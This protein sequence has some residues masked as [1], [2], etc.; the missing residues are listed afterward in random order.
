[1]TTWGIVMEFLLEVWQINQTCLFKLSWGKGHGLD[2]QMPFPKILQQYYQEWTTAYQGY[3]TKIHSDSHHRPETDDSNRG[4]PGIT[5]SVSTKSINWETRLAFAEDQLVIAFRDWLRAGELFEI[6]KTINAYVNKA[7]KP[8]V[9]LVR[10]QDNGDCATVAADNFFLAKLPWE[11]LRADL[12]DRVPIHILRTTA[13]RPV[14]KQQKRR[15]RLRILAVFGDDDGL[16]F[17]AERQAIDQ[18]LK[19]IAYVQF[20]GYNISTTTTQTNLKT[21]ISQAIKDPQGWDILFFA[22]H[23]D[24]GLGGEVMLAPGYSALISEFEDALKIARD[25]GLQFALFNSCRGCAIA[26]SLISYGLSHVVVMRERVSNQVAQVFFQEF[27]DRLAKLEDV[28]MAAFGATQALATQAKERYQHPSAYLLPSIYAYPGVKPLKPP[29]LNWRVIASMLNPT[30]W[31]AIALT[32]LL[33]LSCQPTVQYPLIDWRQAAQ[34]VYRTLNGP[35]T[36]APPI[37]LVKL[38]DDS[39]QSEKA[40][41]N[42]ID[43]GYIAKLM[44][45]AIDLKIP[46]VGIDY[47]LKD[48]MPNQAAVKT[49]A[50]KGRFIF[51]ASDEWGVANAAAVDPGL[52]IDGDIGVNIFAKSYPVFLARTIGDPTKIKGKSV[53]LH[54]FPYQ[55]FCQYQQQQGNCDISD[56][57]VY[58]NPITAAARWFGQAWLNPWIDYSIPMNKVYQSISSAEFLKESQSQQEIA[59]L[60]P[61]EEFDEYQFPTTHQESRN[62]A[63]MA[64]GEIHAYLLYN[65]LHQGLIMPFPDLWMVGIVG[66]ISKVLVFWL[67]QRPKERSVNRRGWLLLL[68]GIPIIACAISL[69][70]YIGLGIAIPVLF[71]VVTYFSYVIPHWL[72]QRKVKRRQNQLLNQAMIK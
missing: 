26:E 1:L 48:D 34:G 66:I 17:K 50:S 19:P 33:V 57:K 12:S 8:I 27:V 61:S 36:S 70:I 15:S 71:P 69:Q 52:R 6:R 16:D 62:S 13:Q 44:N 38:D 45:K 24:D 41:K 18:K 37:L 60:V 7:S 9:L 43:R 20:E 63:H 59:L 29:P 3:A 46:T 55:I 47:V 28:Q 67:Q 58:Y 25:Q 40:S 22:G 39:L 10:C 30:R 4:R 42:P 53:K 72:Q 5:G 21:V 32:A 68:G 51:G 11:S 64:G 2:A 31:E 65:L 23:S 35:E 56:R 49:A 14:I 54:S